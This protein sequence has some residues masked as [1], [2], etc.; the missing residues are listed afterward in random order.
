[1]GRKLSQWCKK[2]KIALI[3]KDIY[4]ISILADDIGLSRGHV[5]AVVNGRAYS[6]NTVKLIDDYLQSADIKKCSKKLS[7]WC[8]K[9]KIALIKKDMS[10][11]EL[12]DE[13]GMSRG[14]VSAVIN[15]RAYSQNT[16][17]LISDYFNI[18]FD[19]GCTL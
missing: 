4:H 12:A 3:E 18:P 8:K 6:Q 13:L 7:P 11:T 5:S 15:G 1:M 16:V 2:V 9:T 14:H 19:C 10:I 17:K